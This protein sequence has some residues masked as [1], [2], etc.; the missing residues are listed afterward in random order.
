MFS[1][2]ADHL[3][4]EGMRHACENITLPQTSFAGGNNLQQYTEKIDAKILME[5]K[6]I[7]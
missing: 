7:R 2:D 3:Q 6:N 4:T 5:R 1:S